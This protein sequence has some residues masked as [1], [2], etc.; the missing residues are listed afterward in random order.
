[1][2]RGDSYDSPNTKK[3]TITVAE[4]EVDA[5]VVMD[6]LSFAASKEIIK[7]Y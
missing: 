1:M 3:T 5:G 7:R 4:W 2:E 6:S